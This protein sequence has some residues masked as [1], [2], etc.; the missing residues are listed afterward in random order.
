MITV[1]SRIR[2]TNP[3]WITGIIVLLGVANLGWFLGEG[4][5]RKTGLITADPYTYVRYAKNL[6]EGHYAV[7]GVIADLTE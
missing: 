1:L 3:K 5:R 4:H 7:Q 6:A 2:D